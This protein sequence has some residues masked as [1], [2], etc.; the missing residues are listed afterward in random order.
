MAALLLGFDLIPQLLE[1][2]H[3]LMLLLL[4]FTLDLTDQLLLGGLLL[5]HLFLDFPHL[6]DLS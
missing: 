2:P 1:P 6:I 4:Q 5:P 3:L